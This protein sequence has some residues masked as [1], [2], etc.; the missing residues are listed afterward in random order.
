MGPLVQGVAPGIAA[1]NTQD[2]SPEYR[3]KDVTQPALETFPMEI[4]FAGQIR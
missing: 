1:G 3:I 4:D 2:R